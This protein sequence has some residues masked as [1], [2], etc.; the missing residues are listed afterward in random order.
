METR[1]GTDL[2]RNELVSIFLRMLEYYQGILFLTSN[3]AEHI[4]PA[5]ESRIDVSLRYP[6]LDKTSRRQ[7]WSR[8][9][10]SAKGRSF[11]DEDLDKLAAVSL[12]G[13]QIK[14]VLKTANLLAREQETAL[15]YGQV[16]TVL[17]LRALN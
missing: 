12:N 5:F 10:E 1:H 3:R 13:R 8:F 16:Q 6:D 7:I 14:N 11:S 15:A 4:D 9:I 2:Q 17:K